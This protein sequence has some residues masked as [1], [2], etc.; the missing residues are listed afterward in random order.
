MGQLRRDR[1]VPERPDRERD[2]RSLRKGGTMTD[3]SDEDPEERYFI[4]GPDPEVP[5][6]SSI[7]AQSPCTS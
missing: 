1:A 6:A 4:S 3:E 2:R 5:S 7:W